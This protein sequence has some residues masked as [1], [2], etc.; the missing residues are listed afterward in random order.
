MIFGAILAGLASMAGGAALWWHNHST[1]LIN[2]GKIEA[3]AKIRAAESKS[4]AKAIA[5]RA[6][7][8]VKDAGT[9]AGVSIN[10]AKEDN[11]QKRAL[12]A[13]QQWKMREFER[14]WKNCL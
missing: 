11:C 7:V 12:Q 10:N 2:Q 4:D 13:R 8:M 1:R 5:Q 9:E 6:S 14:I 3:T